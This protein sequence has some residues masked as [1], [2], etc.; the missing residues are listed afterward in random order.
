[1]SIR[2][3]LPGRLDR[4]EPARAYANAP[5]SANR[6]RRPR[7][8]KQ[9]FEAAMKAQQPVSRKTRPTR[10]AWLDPRTEFLEPRHHL[11]CLLGDSSR[12][13]HDE[14]ERWAA[15]KGFSDTKARLDPLGLCDGRAFADDLSGARLGAERNRGI[16]RPTRT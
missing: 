2:G 1:M 4:N 13:R 16:E 15:G 5:A 7:A 3:A 12:I 14:L 6:K 11:L 9:W 8:P 10:R